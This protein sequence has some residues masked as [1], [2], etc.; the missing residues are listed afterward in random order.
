M[1]IRTLL[2]LLFFCGSAAFAQSKDTAE[3]TAFVLSAERWPDG[4]SLSLWQAPWRYHAGDDPAWSD[5]KFDDHT[6]ELARTT[7]LEGSLP[8]EAWTGVGWFRF[9]IIVDSTFRSRSIGITGDHVGTVR[10][11]WDG[12]L[13]LDTLRYRIPSELHVEPGYHVLAVRYELANLEDAQKE[14]DYGGFYVILGE[15]E[16]AVKWMIHQKAEQM[17]FVGILLAFAILHLILFFYSISARGNLVYALFLVVYAAALYFDIQ[18][19]FLTMSSADSYLCLIAHRAVL[20]VTSTLF[21]LFLYRIFY[22]HTPPQF[23]A[24][25][26]IMMI[27]GVIIV[28][29]P[30]RDFIYYVIGSIVIMLEM[31]R[32]LTIAV[33]KHK[34]GA[35]IMATGFII[36][37]VFSTYD[38]LLDLNLLA[39]ISNVTN[40]YYFGLLGL[41]AATSVYLARDFS[42]MS[43]RLV[44]QVKRTQEEEIARQVVEKDN[45]RKTRELEE[46]RQLQLSMLPPCRNDLPGIDMCF[47][48]ITATE[49]GGDYYDFHY[50]EDSL[51]LAVGDATGHGMKAGTMVSIIKSLFITNTPIGDVPAFL[52]KCSEAIKAMRMGNL[53][54]GLSI[55]E[56]RGNRLTVSSAGMPP[57]LVYR[58][59]TGSVEEIVIKSMPLGGPGP[60][61]YEVQTTP[62]DSG[63]ILL[64]MSDGLAELFNTRGEILDYPRVKEWFVRLADRS[65]T[66]IAHSLTDQG[67]TWAEGREQ[68]DDMTLVVVKKM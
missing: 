29:N 36:L 7:L 22:S 8:K 52:R 11:Y 66:E 5:P 55:A 13:V 6:W 19:S 63:D 50:S 2:I 35:W 58:K 54:M 24:V 1:I 20:P 47:H 3:E 61:D 49:V 23:W 41:V 30:Q 33:V 38:S 59:A 48:M 53:F 65:A 57:V 37:L 9:H 45:L 31:M 68:A 51:V 25:A 10:L 46:A 27:I 12:R 43:R 40:A 67:R 56:I 42:Q 44:E 26:G 17:F 32:V 15:S 16:N 28:R 39:P 60:M 62:F 21:L 4:G 64:M 34:P 14:R 18:Q